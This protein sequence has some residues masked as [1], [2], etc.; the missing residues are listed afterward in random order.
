MLSFFTDPYHDELLYSVCA[1]YHFYSG[2]LNLNDTMIDL[3]GKSTGDPI[4]EFGS[5]LQFL[6]DE[7]GGNYKSEKMIQNH[8]V[9]P[10]YQVFMPVDRKIKVIDSMKFFG[11]SGIWRKIGVCWGKNIYK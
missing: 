6:C 9:F 5:N 4:F 10:F 3:F 7:I 11:G 8:T 2:N 1:R